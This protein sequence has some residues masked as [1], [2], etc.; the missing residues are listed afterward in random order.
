MA[1]AN[2]TAAH[3]FGHHLQQSDSEWALDVLA[4]LRHDH[5][6]LSR[7][8][9]EA[10]S[11]RVAV[12]LLMPAAVVEEAWTGELTPTFV[13]A[14]TR[15]GLVSRQAATL[16][17]SSFAAPEDP[18]AVIVVADP[19]TGA[20]LSS[21]SSDTSTLARPAK[22]SV[23]S[24]FRALT[25]GSE[26][27]RGAA[28]GF[29]YVTGSARSDITYDWGWDAHHTYVFIVARPTYRFGNAQWDRDAVECS[30]VTCDST[31]SHHTATRCGACMLPICPDCGACGCEKQRGTVCMNCFTE[32]SLS[33]SQRG[34][35][36]DE[37]PI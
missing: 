7:H 18:N 20:V 22:G 32:M 10:V 36:H 6:T 23:Q 29:E 8:V 17:A 9:E 15:G 26:G 25:S 35:V 16:R 27:R 4:G 33:E 37:C 28:T 21:V 31:F 13:R 30:S 12:T 2:F 3:E 1:R 11:N 5:N 24:D 14:L 34:T 19:A